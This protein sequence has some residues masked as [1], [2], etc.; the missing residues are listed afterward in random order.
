MAFISSAFLK[1]FRQD[2]AGK[3]V[4]IMGLGLQGRGV[5]D[6]RFL[7]EM[8]AQVTAT[9][10]KTADE[11]APSL[12][13]LQGLPI[14]FVLGQHR[15]QDF[16][17]AQVVVRNAGVPG[18]SPYLQ[19]AREAG[20]R[21]VMDE[22]LF[23]EYAPVKVIGV[24]GTRG[25]TTT[26]T[27]IY[28]IL[29]KAFQDRLEESDPGSEM[30]GKVVFLAGNI[31]GKATLP[32]LQ[33]VKK[34]DWVVME[35]SSW[36]LQ[37]F[38]PI[39]YSPSI[40]VIT[41]IFPDHLNRYRSMAEYV[42]DKK[43]LFRFHKPGDVLVLNQDQAEVRALADEA[44]KSRVV[45]FRADDIP[46]D[47]QLK[48]PGEHNRRNLAAALQVARQ[49]EIEDKIVQQVAETFPGVEYRLQLI[50]E[51]NS[52]G[53]INDTTSTTPA[54]LCA[55]ME[56]FDK[57]M[58]LLA[59]G[60]S[61]N[62]PLETAARKVAQRA[63]HVVLLGGDATPQFAQTLKRF[64]AGGKLAGPFTDFKQAVGKAFS[65]A[66]PGELVVLSPGFASFGMFANEFDRGDQFN[67][68]VKD[69]AH[70]AETHR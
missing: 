46:G 8:G 13:Q 70:E 41:S 33:E 4:L 18:D 19:Q 20:A 45:W 16:R 50:K 17:E 24:T 31:L 65:L 63:K 43:L 38:E 44:K 53:F 57:P 12:K 26:A 9:D 36:Q 52:V 37:G 40:A 10:L 64:G 68:I 14:K 7:A 2:F 5:G 6:A 67:R 54:A 1:H 32:L 35:L 48:L 25:K 21:I 22:A 42:A 11:L 28:E 60:S 66:Q 27:L 56:A 55:A 58:I 30:S 59:G 62:L 47:W 49:V 39:K 61:K 15:E 69:L 23:V 34:D 51:I 29:K 3:K